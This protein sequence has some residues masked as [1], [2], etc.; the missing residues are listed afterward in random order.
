MAIGIKSSKVNEYSLK[1]DIFEL[2]ISLEHIC[3]FVY[4]F[5]FVYVYLFYFI[6]F[7][8]LFIYLF[9]Y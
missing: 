1:L 4:L 7:I 6:L 5:I 2:K 9:I 3:L 8:C